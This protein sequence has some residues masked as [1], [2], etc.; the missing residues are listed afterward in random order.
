MSRTRTAA[1]RDDVTRRV[2]ES[3][4]QQGHAPDT[5]QGCLTW[6]ERY[7][8]HCGAVTDEASRLTR[9]E[10]TAFARHYVRQIGRGAVDEIRSKIRLWARTLEIVGVRLPAWSEAPVVRGRIPE[11]A[12]E[13]RRYMVR[14]RGLRKSTLEGSPLHIERLQRRQRG[15]PLHAIRVEDVDRFLIWFG[16]RVKPV[17]VASAC[18]SLRAFLRFLHATARISIDLA[19]TIIGP[20]RTKGLPR[21]LP[22]R[23]VQ[24]IL[25]SI[26][27]STAVGKRDYAILFTMASY[28]FGAGEITHLR[29][30]DLDWRHQTLRVVRPKTK[31]EVVVPLIGAVGRAIAV[32]LR[33][34]RPQHAR[35]SRAVFVAFRAP[36]HPLEEQG[37]RRALRRA[38]RAAG[39]CAADLGAHAFRHSHA[40]MQVELGAPPRVVSEILGHRSPSSLSTYVRVAPMRL[41]SICLSVPTP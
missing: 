25:H 1:I 7:R 29:L 4:T 2:V 8:Q 40:T 16:Q 26:D 6:A 10:V 21:A 27:R 37:V 31:V 35:P 9:R 17:T 28:G 23:D 20:R 22:W 33:D 38:A 36:H 24:R 5:I 15:R 14:V 41:R 3:L 12:E 18:W 32:Y 34:A 11:L 19:A 13:Y 39:V 30:D